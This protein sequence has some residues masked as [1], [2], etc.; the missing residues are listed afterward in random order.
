MRICT[1]I[2]F[3]VLV[4]TRF[5]ASLQGNSEYWDYVSYFTIFKG[6]NSYE[7][8]ENLHKFIGLFN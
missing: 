8:T 6:L 3:V 7:D 1:N 4:E 2:G 5:I